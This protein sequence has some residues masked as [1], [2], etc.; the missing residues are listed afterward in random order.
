MCNTG[1]SY[2]FCTNQDTLSYQNLVSRTLCPIR[3]SENVQH[4]NYC[5]PACNSEWNSCSYTH[6]NL[7]LLIITHPFNCYVRIW[8]KK[9]ISRNRKTENRLTI[10]CK[11]SMPLWENIQQNSDNY[12]REIKIPVIMMT[13]TQSDI[14]E[15]NAYAGYYEQSNNRINAKF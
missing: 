9:Y 5:C 13:I 1:V 2:C 10:C 12:N 11:V 7:S 4:C 15:P 8:K 14:P 6:Q 3:C